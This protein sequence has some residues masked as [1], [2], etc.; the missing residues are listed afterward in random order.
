VHEA[1]DVSGGE[2]LS[3][4]EGADGD[5]SWAGKTQIAELCKMSADNYMAVAEIDGKWH[6]W[7]VLG[8]YTL[9]EW[10]TPDGSYHKEFDN[11][12]DAHHY[13]HKV[14]SEEIVEYGVVLC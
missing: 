14:C 12:L 10:A 2:S 7:M 8:G 4:Q 5:L 13:A 6:V 9:E 1:R 11:E 3:E